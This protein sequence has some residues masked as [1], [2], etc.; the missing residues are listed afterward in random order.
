MQNA[1]GSTTRLKASAIPFPA[2]PPLPSPSPR[3][4][5]ARFP[6]V[7]SPVE[8]SNDLSKDTKLSESTAAQP[9]TPS[10]AQQSPRAG[11]KAPKQLKQ[12]YSSPPAPEQSPFTSN[13]LGIAFPASAG[14]SHSSQSLDAANFLNFSPITPLNHAF[15]AS[16][17]LLALSATEPE[18]PS[19]SS[20]TTTCDVWDCFAPATCEV[21]PCSCVLCHRHLRILIHG[22][23]VVEAGVKTGARAA[24]SDED[25][26]AQGRM[27][28]LFECVGCRTQ[29]QAIEKGRKETEEDLVA[30]LDEFELGSFG[31]RDLRLSA[32][33]TTEAT[34]PPPS[35]PPPRPRKV[36]L[37][38]TIIQPAFPLTQAVANRN[39][40]ASSPSA[41][42]LFESSDPS[43]P[44]PFVRARVN[45][46][47]FALPG[48]EVVRRAPAS[49]DF[50]DSSSSPPSAAL[51]P[52][53]N[54]T[55]LRLDNIPW[56]VTVAEIAEW[57]PEDCRPRSEGPSPSIHIVLH[58]Q[59]GRTL[60]RCFVDNLGPD[61]VHHVVETRQRFT[62]SGRAISV[63]AV[64]H[65]E[66]MQALFHQ[67]PPDKSKLNHGLDPNFTPRLPSKED[68]DL[69]LRAC[70]KAAAPGRTVSYHPERPFLNI[71]QLIDKFP[72]VDKSLW[73]PFN[74]HNIFECAEEAASIALLAS[75]R[76]SVFAHLAERLK[77]IVITST[78]KLSCRLPLQK[79]Y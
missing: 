58:R 69:L 51:P 1:Q 74:L 29:S 67:L 43:P 15:P 45:S 78:G 49:P 59:S 38:S 41:L 9:S 55:I 52:A 28:K 48:G 32:S 26:A 17:P 71:V 57:L 6:P 7:D 2:P 77:S 4:E 23:R 13:A 53:T 61:A 14:S 33:P 54:R 12:L 73:T 10:T 50:G 25:V 60:P 20:T 24:G 62:L 64:A 79:R 3:E 27:K 68:L 63:R 34:S 36:T 18:R 22:A 31:V 37:P 11:S 35:P 72:W 66:L 47:P 76:D 30:G 44:L 21:S 65:E 56:L 40:S 5:P 16:P 42:D 75:K 39:R 46:A 8:P 70:R 19:N